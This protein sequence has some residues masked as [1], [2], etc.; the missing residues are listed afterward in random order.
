MFE[1]VSFRFFVV[2]EAMRRA[3]Q[4][5]KGKGGGGDIGVEAWVVGFGARV[6]Y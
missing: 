4:G 3:G 1:A 5:C 2:G 6:S